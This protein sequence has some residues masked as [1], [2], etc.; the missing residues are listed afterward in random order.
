[1][2]VT[3]GGRWTSSSSASSNSGAGASSSAAETISILRSYSSAIAIDR[4]VGE[5]LGERRHLAH[6]HQ[7]LDQL[8]RAQTQQFGEITDGDPGTDLGCDAAR[9]DRSGSVKALRAADGDGGH[10]GGAADD[11]GAVLHLVS[12]R[13][14]CESMTTRRR[15]PLAPPAAAPAAEVL[16]PGGPACWKASGNRLR[17]SNRRRV[18]GVF[19]AGLRGPSAGLRLRRGLRRP[20]FAGALPAASAGF[21]SAFRGL[22]LRLRGG[23]RSAFGGGLSRRPCRSRLR[24]PS[25]PPPR[26]RWRRPP[27]PR[28]RQP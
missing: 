8:G 27:W 1:M 20:A 19:G 18:A 28:L 6:H 26:R 12:R 3:T 22:R 5:G 16:R 9:R 7:L 10:R 24:A 23:L 17:A 15:L 14:A 13:D 25:S 11:A 21:A 4:L 2:I